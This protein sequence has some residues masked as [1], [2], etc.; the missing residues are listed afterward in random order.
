MDKYQKSLSLD[1]IVGR[2]VASTIFRKCNK[3][4]S[5]CVT[6]SSHYEELK[7]CQIESDLWRL[8]LFYHQPSYPLPPDSRLNLR[9]FGHNW[10]HILLPP[11][12]LKI[13]GYEILNCCVLLCSRCVKTDGGMGSASHQDRIMKRQIINNAKPYQESSQHTPSAA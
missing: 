7:L 8:A 5:S 1:L 9:R 11:P 2:T 12:Q 4:K 13:G 6:H 3:S 10:R